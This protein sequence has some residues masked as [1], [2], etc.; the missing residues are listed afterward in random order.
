MEEK[1]VLEKKKY[2]VRS[3]AR[4][5]PVLMVRI[6]L[7]HEFIKWQAKVNHINT[8]PFN[9]P[10]YHVFICRMCIRWIGSEVVFTSGRKSPQTV[11]HLCK[12]GRKTINGQRNCNDSPLSDSLGNFMPYARDDLG[13]IY[14]FMSWETDLLNKFFR[15]Q[16]RFNI[17]PD[18]VIERTWALLASAMMEN[19]ITSEIIWR[20]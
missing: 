7:K 16:I 2:R 18:F 15:A 4:R 10:F 8:N 11:Q 12:H 1:I 19:M 9:G 3:V 14:A 6:F 17:G 13:R 20:V 5:K